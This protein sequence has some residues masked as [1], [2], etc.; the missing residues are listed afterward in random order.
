MRERDQQDFAT[1][2]HPARR[3]RLGIF[4]Y[5]L[6]IITLL[7]LGVLIVVAGPPLL[8]AVQASA[9]NAAVAVGVAGVAPENAAAPADEAGHRTAYNDPV[10]HRRYL[11]RLVNEAR[12]GV[13][14]APLVL[15]A[16]LN[17]AARRHSEDMAARE[18]LDHSSGDGSDL[19]VRLADE[20][21]YWLEITQTIFYI[22][23]LDPN[24]AFSQW[25]G[26]EE[27]RPKLL[28]TKF[29]QVGIAYSQSARGL[30]Y[31]TIVLAKPE[32]L[33]AP[34]ADINN[35]GAV[36]QEDQ[37]FI[38]LDLLNQN[39][40]SQ[41]MDTLTIDALLTEAAMRH[42]LDMAAMD[43]MSHEGSDG[44]LPMDRVTATGY[45]WGYVGENVLVRANL[46]APAAFNQWWN[47]PSHYE[48]MMSPRFTEIGI[49]WATSDSGLVYYAMELGVPR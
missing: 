44:S 45:L 38:I 28:A 27:S 42:A 24:L 4:D 48:A 49:A 32:A 33:T 13:G 35:P 9:A 10:E 40:L 36:T 19:A 20:G 23:E 30:Y 41:G 25:H 16:Q 37:T 26:M 12:A 3:G 18:T 47:S 17:A 31:Y 15:N 43:S 39:R 2:E 7:L 14:A 8:S 1:P 34:G 29:E 46:H 5:T 22:G 6:L 21:Y 11:L